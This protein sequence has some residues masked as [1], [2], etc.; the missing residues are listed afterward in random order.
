M[1]C[2]LL[3]RMSFKQPVG[4]GIDN[5]AVFGLVLVMMV[6]KVVAMVL[7]LVH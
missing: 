4:V 5:V 6:V 2:D 3:L 7:V 1:L